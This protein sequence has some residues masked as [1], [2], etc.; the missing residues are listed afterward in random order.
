MSWMHLLG[1][2]SAVQSILNHAWHSITYQFWAS[3]TVTVYDITFVDA[4]FQQPPLKLSISSATVVSSSSMSNFTY[5]P[6]QP[7]HF[8]VWDIGA[9]KI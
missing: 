1:G 8:C 9:Y 6:N 4:L 5:L 3:T 2:M 7:M